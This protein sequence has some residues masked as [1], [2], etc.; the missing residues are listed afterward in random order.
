MVGLQMDNE[1]ERIG[2]ETVV[3]NGGTVPELRKDIKNLRQ[4]I[5]RPGKIRTKHLLNT[6]QED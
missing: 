3:A 5:L 6:S 1:L 2:K 4:S